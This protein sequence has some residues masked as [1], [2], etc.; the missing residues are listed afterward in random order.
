MDI[1]IHIGVHCTD[2]DRLLKA[3][4]KNKQTLTPRGIAVPGP[5]RYRKLVR[6]TLETLETAPPPKG[7]REAL[8]DAI[9]EEDKVERIVLSNANMLAVPPQ[10]FKSGRPYGTVERRL[11]ALAALFAGDRIEYFV[12]L[13]NPATYLPQ[14][15]REAGAARPAELTGGTPPEAL[16]WSDLIARMR[17]ADP[18]AAITVWANEDSP[19]L[20]ETI[21]RAMSGIEDDEEIAGLYDL[22]SEL[23]T[24]HGMRR[25]HSYLNNHPPRTSGQRRRVVSA[26]LEK[27]S[28]EETMIED[29]TV[30]G[31]TQDF[32]DRM[33]DDYEADLE[34]IALID[35]VRLLRP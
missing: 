19:L 34:R 27:F 6:E 35:G 15:A 7:T 20:W 33:A 9:L 31:W 13:R 14:L 10:V 21:L 29:V 30:P 24:R 32:V 18:D 22:M 26:F 3:L 23:M 5:S 25:F 17:T 2:E 16:R 11:P 1:A 4:L 8:L 12:G 28:V